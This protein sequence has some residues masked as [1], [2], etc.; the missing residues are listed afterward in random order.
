M[1]L[2]HGTSG[3]S[4]VEFAVVLPLLVLLIIGGTSL[5]VRTTV[6]MALDDAIT[7][8]VWVAARGGDDREVMRTIMETL[9]FARPNDVAYCIVSGGY[10]EDVYGRLR[11]DGS[12]ITNLPLFNAAPAPAVALMTN[13]QERQIVFGDRSVCTMMSPAPPPSAPASFAPG[14][15]PR[16]PAWMPQGG[17]P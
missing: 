4:L 15:T 7:R 10:H 3:A 5:L 6:I 9:P 11:Y 2:R 17:W 8:A 13:L 1:C 16:G 12:L 14:D